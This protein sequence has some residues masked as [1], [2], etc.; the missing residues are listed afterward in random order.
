MPRYVIL[1]HEMPGPPRG[2]IHWDFMIEQGEV[3][4][5]WAL[6]A[7]PNSAAEIE[8]NVLADHR[9]A[10]LDYEGPVSGNR[11]AVVRWDQGQ[12]ETL[13]DSPQELVVT[14]HGERLKGTARLR[15]TSGNDQRWIF[16]FSSEA[17]A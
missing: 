13:L 12:F 14:L 4:R 2:G 5:T 15:A 7:E 11:G 17:L 8:A 10:Y 9:I 16:E 6:A 3:L 1:R